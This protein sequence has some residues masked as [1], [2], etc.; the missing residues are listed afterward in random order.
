MLLRRRLIALLLIVSGVW[1]SGCHSTHA[2]AAPSPLLAAKPQAAPVAVAKHA[3]RGSAFSVYNNP[4]YGIFFRYP[5]NYSLDEALDS[6]EPAVLEAQRELAAQQPAATLVALVAI[7]PDAYPNTTFRSGTLQF[8]VNSSITPEVCQSFAVPLD[9]TYAFGSTSIQGVTFNWRQRGFAAMGT[10]TLERDY[11][12]YSNGTCYEFL[13]ETV[14]G[15]NPELDPGIKDADE[16]K[17]MHRLD[18]IVSSL[19]IHPEL[20]AARASTR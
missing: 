4:A 14:T 1:H 5:R 17:I 13:L 10:G 2:Q 11:A 15:S 20:P 12:G 16:A 8:A 7:P 19:Q 3:P 18:K 6:E 9:G